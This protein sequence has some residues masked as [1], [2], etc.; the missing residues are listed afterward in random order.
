MKIR[1][2]ILLI[3]S[4]ITLYLSGWTF[5][6]CI[7]LARTGC[8]N[9]S[10][11]I[12]I[13]TPTIFIIVGIIRAMTTKNTRVNLLYKIHD[14]ICGI[15]MFIPLFINDATDSMTLGVLLCLLVIIIIFAEIFYLLFK[16]HLS[17]EKSIKKGN[18]DF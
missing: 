13:L 2:I 17:K 5:N 1:K 14:F 10:K 7:E 3:L 4:G 8:A 18:N 11:M 15:L 12:F 16:K 6:I 9:D